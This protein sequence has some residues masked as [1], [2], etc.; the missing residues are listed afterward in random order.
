M[1]STKRLEIHF[2]APIDRPTKSIE[3]QV[4]WLNDPEI[5]RYS[6]QRHKKHNLETQ[7]SYLGH[8]VSSGNKFGEVYLDVK[9]I[10]TVTAYIDKPNSVANVGILIGE[11]SIWGQGYGHEAWRGFCNYLLDNGA[12]KIEAGMMGINFGMIHICRKY[13]MQQEGRLT[14]HFW[15]KDQLVD[16]VM[17]GK[18]R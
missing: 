3:T 7:K 5:V 8:F 14:D 10:G 12:R 1:I 4:R 13:G 2:S 18:T 6:E 17:F 11:K 9:L 15:I 16:L